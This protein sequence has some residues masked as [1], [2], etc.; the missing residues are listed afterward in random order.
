[1]DLVVR[2]LL[3]G[4]VAGTLTIVIMTPLDTARTR[5]QV[6]GNQYRS[7]WDVLRSIQREEGVRALYK[8]MLAPLCAQAVY[9]MVMFSTFGL[10]SR[11]LERYDL[12]VAS[13]PVG[14]A[15]GALSGGI[16]SLVVTPVE[17]IRNKLAIQKGFV[18]LEFS[19]PTDVIKHVM[20]RE[21]VTGMVS[22][23][24]VTLIKTKLTSTLQFRGLFATLIRDIIGVGAYFSV[25]HGI[26]A[27]LSTNERTKALPLMIQAPIAGACAGVAYWTLALPTDAIKTL[28][29]TSNKKWIEAAREV[30]WWRVYATSYSLAIARGIPGSAITFTT[31]TL[32]S[33]FIDDH[34]LSKG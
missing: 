31:Q 2:D 6:S 23:S 32:V 3:A 12:S 16:N 30:S 24:W 10:T 33:K 9:K 11:A 21:G 17:L 5:L 1:M 4:S 13:F 8:G 26:R 34:F 28:V 22:V 18:N 27:Q 19:G 25:F 7:G 15:C 20:A 29:Q 14:F